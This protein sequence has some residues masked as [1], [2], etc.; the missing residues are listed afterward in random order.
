MRTSLF[1]LLFALTCLRGN[2]QG[3]GFSLG[4]NL[5]GGEYGEN[6]VPGNLNEHYAYP[7]ED[8]V[9][10]FHKKGFKTVTIP[11]RWERIQKNLGG[12]LD[13][14]EIGEIKKVVSWCSNKGM[15]VILSMHNGGRYRK[16]GI[17]YIIGSYTVSRNDFSDVWNRLANAF[18]GYQNM[19]GFEIMTEPHEMQGFDW[20]TTAQEAIN[21]I[22]EAD[23]RNTIIISGENY[24]AS[25]SWFDYSDQL[26]NL[27]DPQNKIV[28]NAHC[29]FDIDF[30]GKYLY[31]YEQNKVEDSLGIKRVMPFVD[32]LRQN[33]KKG[34]IGQFGVPDTDPRW[35]NVMQYFLKYLNEQNVTAVYWASGKRWNGNPMSVFPLAQNDR[36]QMGVLRQFVT[37][38]FY[39][40]KP[41]VVA[42]TQSV[43][44]TEPIV[45]AP[46]TVAPLVPAAPPAP[47]E[48]FLFLPGTILLPEPNGGLYKPASAKIVPHDRGV[49]LAKYR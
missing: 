49:R 19:Y 15:Q 28:Y 37:G 43:V 45:T 27:K 33:N 14:Q 1:I 8:E 38:S 47:P 6:T 21:S 39:E 9:N 10:Y 48:S 13:F 2:S 25:E 12:D 17:D 20:F 3:T 36:P 32:W 40:E 30:T 16:N 11:F 29:Y 44:E 4:I 31:S 34:M 42:A 18:S 26:K 5:C 46:V 22:R 24:A 7:T 35:L 41:V 23:R